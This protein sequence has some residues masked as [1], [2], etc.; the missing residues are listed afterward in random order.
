M[1]NARRW[2]GL[3][4]FALA[5]AGTAQAAVTEGREYTRLS[6]PQPTDSGGK[7]EVIEYF[8][9]GCPHCYALEPTLNRWVKSL[10][11]DVEFRRV[12]ALPTPRWMPLARTYYTLEALGELDRLHGQVFDAI[13]RDS[14][15]L[16]QPDVQLEWMAKHGIDKKKFTDAWNSFTVQSKVK[17]AAQLTQA[18]KIDSVPSLVVDGKYVAS[19][20]TAGGNDQLVAVLNELI[21]KARSEHGKK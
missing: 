6:P 11:K 3:F 19:V 18:A 1:L 14:V 16:D 17:R 15:R 12:P 2:L 7:V 21:A 5:C 13:H 10:P 9:Y 4:L 8:W 20:S